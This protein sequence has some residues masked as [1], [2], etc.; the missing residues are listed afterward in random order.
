MSTSQTFAIKL[1]RLP[2]VDAGPGLIQLTVDASRGTAPP[3]KIG[4]LTDAALRGR[5]GHFNTHS[6]NELA[7]IRHALSQ[8]MGEATLYE[9]WSGFGSCLQFWYAFV[10]SQ[11]RVLEWTCEKCG[12]ADQAKIGGSVGESFLRSCKCGAATKI[13]VPK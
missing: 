13:T 7:A 1:S 12:T 8:D 3:T 2:K 6:A 4:A 5:L 10:G 9:S 11:I